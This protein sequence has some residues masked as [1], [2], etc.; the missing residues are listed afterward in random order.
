M[1]KMVLLIALCVGMFST[2]NAQ[3]TTG[4]STSKVIK[5]G[6]RAQAGD[7]GLYFGGTTNM[8][9]NL[10]DKNIEFTTLPLI[11]FKYMYTDQME[12][13]LGLEF[14]KTK[15]FQKYEIEEETEESTETTKGKT[16]TLESR[17]YLYPGIAYHFSTNNLLD[18]YVG[19]EMPIGW[20]RYGVYNDYSYAGDN[21]Y[22]NVTKTTFDIGLG[23]F[24][25]LQAYIA[26]LPLAIGVEYGLSTM[27]HCGDKYKYEAKAGEGDAQ[28]YYTTSLEEGAGQYD[29]LKVRKTEVG[30]Q[31]RFTLTYYFK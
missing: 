26:N 25:G 18:V 4:K 12:F 6:N 5:T 27:L 29:G 3:I 21:G 30:S 31:V 28:V 22:D 19:A 9:K 17:N 15:N 14:W 13:R 8:F 11:N 10:V 7:Y 24:I 1:K 16:K 20:S 23:G 2:V